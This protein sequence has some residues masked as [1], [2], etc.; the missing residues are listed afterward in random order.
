MIPTFY[1][2]NW[3]DLAHEIKTAC[4]WRC[5]VCGR[6]CRRPGEPYRGWQYQLHVAHWWHEYESPTAFV[7]AST[8]SASKHAGSLSLPSTK[9]LEGRHQSGHQN[10]LKIPQY[11]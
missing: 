11:V 6:Q 4:E 8:G 3:R 5:L 9:H 2:T 7:A 10:R 1:P